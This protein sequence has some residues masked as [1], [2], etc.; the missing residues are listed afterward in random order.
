MALIISSGTSV[1]A[2]PSVRGEQAFA[3][4]T[5]ARPQV[6][7]GSGLRP[8]EN[9]EKAN[10]AAHHERII[11]FNYDIQLSIQLHFQN[12]DTHSIEEGDVTL[13]QRMFMAGLRLPFL[14]IARELPTFLGWRRVRSFPTLGAICSPP[15]FLRGTCSKPK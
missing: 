7:G 14:G 9:R 8:L 1:G 12:L 3:G 5:S 11:R 15:S 4:A 6:K 2:Q 13:F 10:L